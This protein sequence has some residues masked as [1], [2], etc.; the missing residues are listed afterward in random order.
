MIRAKP[1]GWY[2]VAQ[3]AHAGL[4]TRRS[5]ARVLRVLSSSAILAFLFPGQAP[6]LTI[7][8]KFEE[9]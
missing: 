2:A 3:A 5:T 6:E 7:L 1:C 4:P 9:T 8:A